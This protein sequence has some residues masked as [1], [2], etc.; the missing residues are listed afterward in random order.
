MCLVVLA[1]DC[2]PRY[3]VVLAANRDEFHDRPAAPLDWWADAPDIL[4]GRDLAAGG[5]WLGVDRHGRL[6][7]VTNFREPEPAAPAGTS[8]GTLVPRFLSGEAGA[9]DFAARVADE[10]PPLAGFSLIVV[11]GATAAYAANRPRA[12]ARAL[13]PGVYGLGNHGLDT[14]WPKVALTRERFAA[15]LAA[16]R[17]EAGPLLRLMAERR[18]APDDALPRSGIGLERERLLSSPFVVSEDYGT[19]C[20]TVALV[21][22][23]GLVRIEER[24]YGRDGAPSERTSFAFIARNGRP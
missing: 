15:A 6:G 1:F 5:T 16:E 19:R 23:D 11:D 13:E 18:P 21:G 24:R 20:T 17:L 2:H 12:E 7:V 4:A 3:R 9:L 8:R 10:S 14:P 22:R